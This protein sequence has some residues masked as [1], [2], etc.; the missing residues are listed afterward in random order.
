MTYTKDDIR[1]A[2]LRAVHG[3][4]SNTEAAR[5]LQ[6]SPATIR[7]CIEGGDRW[8][9]MSGATV[10]RMAANLGSLDP[11][12]CS[13]LPVRD[14]VAPPP[15]LNE[16]AVNDPTL[17]VARHTGMLNERMHEG[18]PVYTLQDVADG[19][20]VS[21]R[22]IERHWSDLRQ[23]EMRPGRDYTAIFV[24]GIERP[25]FY[26]PGVM[27]LAMNVGG[28]RAKSIRRHLRDLDEAVAS[29]QIQPNPIAP[30][31]EVDKLAA[32]LGVALPQIQHATTEAHAM[33]KAAVI[34]AADA[35]DRIAALTADMEA[36]PML[37][38]R[39]HKAVGRL[40]DAMAGV[41]MHSRDTGKNAHWLNGRIGARWGVRDAL[42]GR[43]LQAAI[44]WVGEQH[45]RVNRRL[46]L[47]EV[48]TPEAAPV[49]ADE[50]KP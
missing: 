7:R 49:V 41:G 34:K 16:P 30:T 25:V 50:V 40:A 24:G 22:T 32:V 10:A 37:R 23:D 14:T 31:S 28:D 47:I 36:R 1:Q 39:L 6:V 38:R 12:D 20:D 19:L 17:P 4:M 29:G 26:R 43:Q 8:Q 46:P 5:R 44:D 33:A 18:H 48:L 9:E 27:L 35:E 3:G 42:T 21:L 2:L 11:M 13:P 15:P 45:E